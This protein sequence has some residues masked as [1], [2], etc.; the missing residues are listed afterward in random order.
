M[1]QC[2]ICKNGIEPRTK[3]ASL[4]GGLFPAEDPEFFMIDV[5][6][7]PEIVVHH[8]CLLRAFAGEQDSRP[9]G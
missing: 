4:V 1:K 9:K 7:M 2:A 8:A 5:T 3:A 6:V